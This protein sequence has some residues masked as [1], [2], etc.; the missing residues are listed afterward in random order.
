MRRTHRPEDSKKYTTKNCVCVCA[1]VYK[2]D[3]IC[4][5]YHSTL[6]NKIRTGKLCSAAGVWGGDKIPTVGVLGIRF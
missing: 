1:R 5:S 2:K 4:S 3:E 6:K